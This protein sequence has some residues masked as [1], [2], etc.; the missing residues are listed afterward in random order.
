[1]LRIQTGEGEVVITPE[2]PDVQI[3]LMQDGK[4]VEIIDTKT[5]KRVT[6]PVGGYDVRLKD[7]A[8]GLEVKTDRI[9]VRRGRETLVTI[10]YH[11]KASEGG[12]GVV[13]RNGATTRR[14]DP[15]HSEDVAVPRRG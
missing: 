10:E 8:D 3:L 5:Q 13:R 9:R 7:A 1:M 15:Q 12:G 4:Q 2:S 11:P 14:R 6:V